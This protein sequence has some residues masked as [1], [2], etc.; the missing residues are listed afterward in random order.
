MQVFDIRKP[1]S[2]V[3]SIASPVSANNSGSN[4]GSNVKQ[5]IHTLQYVAPV[6][7]CATIA[8]NKQFMEKS[9]KNGTDQ[10]S[11]ILAGSL[12]GVYFF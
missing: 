8:N 12:G 5:P 4:G 10:I 6:Q 1:K 3:L 9:K 11:G 2:A 7:Q